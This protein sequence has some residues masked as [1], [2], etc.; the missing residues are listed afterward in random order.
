MVFVMSLWTQMV[1]DICSRDL[2]LMPTTNALYQQVI[3]TSLSYSHFIH[4][5]LTFLSYHLTNIMCD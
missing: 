4:I 1:S 5:Q 3:R 2:S